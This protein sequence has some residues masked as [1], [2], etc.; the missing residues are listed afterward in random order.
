M[1]LSVIIPCYQAEKYLRRCLNSVLSQS[2]S[3]LEVIIVDDGSTDS[4]MTII[5]D[6]ARRDNRIKYFKQ[7][8]S[9]VSSARN[10][11]IDN[12][13]GDVITFVDSDD[14]IQPQM[15][16]VLMDLLIKYDADIAQ[17]S[18]C[19]DYGDRIKYI[20]NTDQIYTFESEKIAQ[21]LLEA[22]LIGPGCWNKVFKKTI[23]GNIRFNSLYKMGEDTLFT[24]EVFQQAQKA[25]FIDSCYYVY[26]SSDSSA[27]THISSLKRYEDIYRVNQRIYEL[28]KG[29]SY[30]NIAF[31]RW[32]GSLLSK[33]RAYVFV[34]D[35][36]YRR[37]AKQLRK[38]IIKDYNQK[39]YSG[40]EKKEAII[41]K[42]IPFLFKPIYSIYNLIRTPNWDL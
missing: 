37:K 22:K 23:I 21:S 8:N 42:Y 32:K 36:N 39:V 40:T 27:C 30:C 3:D 2:Y 14:I 29:K 20:G 34:D 5:Q 25:V 19:R 12:A 33:Y 24:F 16:Q 4:S 15:Y 7:I 13:S 38:Q 11:G 17:C 10:N 6:F 31:D 26:F 18:Y 1:L 41:I 28:S 35:I 9:G